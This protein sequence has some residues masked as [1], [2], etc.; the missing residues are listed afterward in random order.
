MSAAGRPVA[1]VVL[2]VVAVG[3]LLGA[4]GAVAGT[5]ASAGLP[6][7]PAG[8]RPG[9]AALYLPPADAPQLQNT[10]PWT[11][12]PI[13]VSGAQSYRDGEWLYQDFLNDDH[14][15][16]GLKDPNDPYGASGHLYSPAGGSFTYPTDK[17]YANNAADLVELRVKPLSAATAFRVT[18]NTLEDAARSAFTIALGD[19][20]A[21]AWPHAAGVRSPAKVFL[22]WHGS[23]AELLDAATGKPVTPAPTAAVDLTRRQ[24]TVLVPHAGWDPGTGKVRTTIGVG[25]W[26][27][28]TNAYLAP[29]PGAADATTPGGGTPNG[30]AIVNVGPRFAEPVPKFFGSNMADTAVAGEVSAPWW[31]DRQQSEQLAVGDVTPFSADVDFG[32]LARRVR[33]DSAVPVTGAMDRI[34]ASHYT[35]GQ[36]LDPTKICYTLGT[37][38][39]GAKCIGRFVGQLQ[40]Y[41]LYVPH[42]PVPAK[43]FGLTLLLHSLSANYNQYLA[44][45]NQSELGERDAG[46]V[47]VTPSGRGPDG[48]YKGIAE[49][50]TFETWA[51]VARHYKVDA[52]W[53]DVT[54]YSMGGFG[55]YRLLARW[56]DLFAKG[57]SVV[58]EPQSVSDQLVSLRNTPLLAWNSAEDELVNV[59]TS[60]NAVKADTAAGIRFEE[61][62]FLTADHLTLAANDEFGPG[63]AFLGSARVDRNPFHVT[64]VVDP[65]E[66]NVRATTIADHAYWLSNLRPRTTGNGSVDAVSQAFGTTD[67]KVLPV[68]TGA[69]V[70][71]GG[72]IPAMAYV[73]RSQ[74]WGPL[75]HVAPA[76]ALTLKATNLRTAT[77]ALDRA[78]LT[79]RRTLTLDV[80]ADGPTALVLTGSS[81]AGIHATRDGKPAALTRSGSTLTLPVTSGHAV[82]VLSTGTG[83]VAAAPRVAPALGQLPR[84][85][86]SPAAALLGLVLLGAGLATGRRFARAT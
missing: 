33:D 75:G 84:T 55:T 10:G 38:D 52:D 58:G 26:N 50:D 34:L 32:K 71:I 14:G 40:S 23:T 70:L 12:Q 82:Y 5:S 65:T 18:L 76:N 37:F 46:S 17:V 56:P 36:G 59:N 72:E 57:W 25:L 35:F 45:H 67:A 83:S 73:S 54:G 39:A 6:A 8:H 74:Q 49:A 42:K 78:R 66:D 20:A 29:K 24:V 4:G 9:P 53:A 62:K 1:G 43:G 48:F 77:V 28:A 85:G 7:V 86:G 22:T 68:Q 51:D 31:R 44:S 15:A 80:S 21:V 27:K 13:L 2:A 79:A 64:Y 41:A 61:D 60:E 47:V 81:P 30:V 16:A 3:S 19:G 63:S 11:A 69:G